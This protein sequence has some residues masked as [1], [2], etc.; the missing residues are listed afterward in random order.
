MPVHTSS[1]SATSQPLFAADNQSEQPFGGRLIRLVVAG[2]QRRTDRRILLFVP[3]H[4]SYREVVG[5][6]LERRVLG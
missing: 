5:G 2:Q 1:V 3:N 6:E 4:K